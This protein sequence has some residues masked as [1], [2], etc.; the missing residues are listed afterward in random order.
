VSIGTM[1]DFHAA[2]VDDIRVWTGS[3][4]PNGIAT[5][6]MRAGEQ[7]LGIIRVH[8]IKEERVALLKKWA[9]AEGLAV[10]P[11]FQLAEGSLSGTVDRAQA[12]RYREA[13]ELIAVCPCGIPGHSVAVACEAGNVARAALEGS[14]PA[15]EAT[16]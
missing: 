11:Q 3:N 7:M 10:V 6:T 2:D 14:A 15:V 1:Y 12:A 4:D 9:E 13:L 5:L 8:G 16:S